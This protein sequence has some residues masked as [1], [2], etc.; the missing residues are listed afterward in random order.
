[1]SRRVHQPPLAPLPDAVGRV[2]RSLREE[3]E[4]SQRELGKRMG[5]SQNWVY[6]RE[7]GRV[8]VD[9]GDFMDWCRA[10]GVEPRVGFGGLMNPRRG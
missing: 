10:C 9:V 1:M 8:R 5:V 4:L 6:L 3:A 2:L 7:S